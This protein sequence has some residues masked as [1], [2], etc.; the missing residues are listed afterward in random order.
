[1]AFALKPA[2]A[3]ALLFCG[4]LQ[5][6]YAV[7]TGQVSVTAEFVCAYRAIA[8]QHPDPKLRNPD[9][10]AGKLCPQRAPL[11]RAYEEARKFIDYNGETYAG[12]FYVNARTLYIVSDP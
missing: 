10:L 6:A 2:L 7:K 5:P 12:Y 9:Q 4:V 8:A 11:P 1:M 3:A